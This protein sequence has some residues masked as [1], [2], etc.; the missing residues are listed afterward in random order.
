MKRKFKVGD[1]VRS[2]EHGCGTIVFDDE[3]DLNPL[4]VE[5]D[6]PTGG[7]I[8]RWRKNHSLWTDEK[9]LTII[10]KQCAT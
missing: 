1:R 10:P 7:T 4:V 6:E 2:E 8:G 9:H 5:F 3:S